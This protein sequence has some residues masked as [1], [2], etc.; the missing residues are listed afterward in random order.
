MRRTTTLAITG[1]A[2]IAAVI[3]LPASA[4]PAAEAKADKSFTIRCQ[5]KNDT[6]WVDA[7]FHGSGKPTA[8]YEVYIR[9]YDLS[10]D[11]IAPKVRLRSFNKDGSYTSYR[12]RTGPEGQAAM[13]NFYT[14]LKQPKGLRYV[15]IEGRNSGSYC[16]DYFPK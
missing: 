7:T 14:T 12:W 13:G 11:T 10:S 5:A 8:K 9:T 3:P 16:T 1:L 6:F 2:A 4:Q 15:F